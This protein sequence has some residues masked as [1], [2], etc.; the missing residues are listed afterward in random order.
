MYSTLRRISQDEQII[1]LGDLNARVGRNIDIWHGV[2]G[3]QGV[4]N[5]NS[6]GVAVTNTFCQL[7]DMHRTSWMHPRSKHRQLIDYVI[8]RR[9]DMNEVQIT[10]AMPGED[11]STDHRLIRSTLRQTVRPLALREKLMHN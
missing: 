1:L 11:C 10:P 2:I 7:R 4:D 3:P 6:S 8:V 5:M 9:R